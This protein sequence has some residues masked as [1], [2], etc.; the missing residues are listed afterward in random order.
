[1]EMGNIAKCIGLRERGHKEPKSVHKLKAF[2][3]K[4]HQVV[5]NT[6]GTWSK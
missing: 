2:C 1:M 6:A 3:I 5:V 4:Y